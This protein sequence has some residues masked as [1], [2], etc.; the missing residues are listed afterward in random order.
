MRPRRSKRW[1]R[2]DSA[3][4]HFAHINMAKKEG[5]RRLSIA[6]GAV[7]AVSGFFWVGIESDSLTK[8][9]IDAT[10]LGLVGW[11]AVRLVAWVINGFVG[12]PSVSSEDSR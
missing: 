4:C 7:L 8:A 12:S 11:F 10:I 3:L 6:S 5:V 1:T 2:N 9:C